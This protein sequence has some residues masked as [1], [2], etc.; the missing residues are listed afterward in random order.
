[1]RCCGSRTPRATG[2]AP[3]GRRPT[4]R[5][6]RDAADLA[7]EFFGDEFVDHYVAMRRWEVD[8]FNRVVD[9]WQ[10]ERYFEMI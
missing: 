7:R 8:C 9:E 10:R 5:R 6:C 4:T 1:M 3:S 2:R